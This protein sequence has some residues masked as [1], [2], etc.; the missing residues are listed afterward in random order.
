MILLR[1]ACTFTVITTAIAMH[2]YTSNLV[3]V[4]LCIHIYSV[5]LITCCVNRL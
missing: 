4:V 5:L 1:Y 3:Y 2:E